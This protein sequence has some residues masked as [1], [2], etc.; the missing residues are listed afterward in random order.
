MYLNRKDYFIGGTKMKNEEEKLWECKK[1]KRGCW[2]KT[3]PEKCGNI[4]HYY[5]LPHVYCHCTEFNVYERV[6]YTCKTCSERCD[7]TQFNLT[8]ACGEDYKKYTC[9]FTM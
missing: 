3:K 6:W 4:I 7:Y 9:K 2:A 8:G 5:P 1:C